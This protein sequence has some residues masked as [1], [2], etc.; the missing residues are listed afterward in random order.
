MGMLLA[1]LVVA[2]AKQR[3]N[4]FGKR[5]KRELASLRG[6]SVQTLRC[7]LDFHGAADPPLVAL[8]TEQTYRVHRYSS[9]NNGYHLFFPIPGF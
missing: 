6:L 7:D 1:V 3:A 2:L 5:G 8:G 9:L 4:S